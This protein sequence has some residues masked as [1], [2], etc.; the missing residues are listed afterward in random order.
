MMNNGQKTLEVLTIKEASARYGPAVHAF[1]QWTKPGGPLPCVRTGRKILI[2]AQ[3]IET[4]LKQGNNQ[5]A[6]PEAPGGIRRLK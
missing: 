3:N 4:F 2:A 6:E 5:P 1:R